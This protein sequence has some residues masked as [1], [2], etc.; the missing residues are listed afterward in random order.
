MS[1]AQESEQQSQWRDAERLYLAAQEGSAAVDMYMKR[2]QW[3]NA[4]RVVATVKKVCVEVCLRCS[5]MCMI[6]VEVLLSSSSSSP[7]PMYHLFF[8]PTHLPT[9]IHTATHTYPHTHTHPH[10]IPIYP[11]IPTPTPMDTFTQDEL[12]AAYAAIARQL[13][14][15]ND[16]NTAERYWLEGRQWEAAVQMYAEKGQWQDALR[17]ALRGGGIPAGRQ[18]LW[19]KCHWV[20]VVVVLT[21]LRGMQSECFLYY[22]CAHVFFIANT[23]T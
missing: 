9:P 13:A 2:G 10:H 5:L 3:D 6:Y 14:S 1:L 20:V 23:F 12:P 16:L 7:V 11:P 15:T 8:V 22:K 18:V 4:L 21:M 17:V 19:G